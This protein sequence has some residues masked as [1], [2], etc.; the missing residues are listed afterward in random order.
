MRA[1]IKYL[2]NRN[3]KTLPSGRA[4]CNRAGNNLEGYTNTGL[5]SLVGPFTLVGK[6][7]DVIQSDGITCIQSEIGDLKI[8]TRQHRE[9]T[10]FKSL[11]SILQGCFILVDQDTKLGTCLQGDK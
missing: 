6:I 3:K 4:F 5:E 1:P 11:S 9:I 8:Q 10:M 2:Q 7:T